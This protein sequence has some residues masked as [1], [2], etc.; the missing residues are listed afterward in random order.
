[1]QAL[2]GAE[3][4]AGAHNNITLT[5]N[6]TLVDGAVYSIA[7]NCTDAAGNAATPVTVAG[8]T[9]DAT[10]PTI[11][12]VAPTTGSFV[13][14]TQVSYTLSEN[15]ASATVTWTR[16]GGSADGSS[17]HAQALVGTE[18][19]AGAH[20]N[21]TITNNPTLASGAIYS[22]QF[23]C[24]DAAGHAATPVTMT[25]VTYDN[26][27]P[28]ISAVAPASN[29]FVNTTAVSYTLSENCTSASITWTRTGG[30]ADGSSPHVRALVGGELNAGTHS[31]VIITN[32][33]TLVDGA[34]YSIA[35]ACSDAAGNAAAPVTRTNITFDPSAVVIS[36]VAPASSSYRNNTQVS[37]TFSEA[38]ASASITWTRT[39]GNSDPS[40]PHVRALVG[41]ELAA[42]AHN[43]ITL[44]NNP[45]LV[46]GA[47]YSVQFDCTDFASNASTPITVT[48][49]TYDF[50]A[51]V[52][53]STA[54]PSNAF[55][56][57]TQVDYT[58]SEDCASASITWTHT[59]GVADGASPHVKA[60][61]GAELN[62]GAHTHITITNNPTLVDG[63]VYSIAFNCADAAG[64][65]A[66]T[67]T[68][69]SVTYDITQ[70]TVSISN[71]KDKSTVN[72]GY[73][74]GIANDN[75]GVTQ[76]QFNLD[77]TTW[78]NATYTAPDWKFALPTGASTWRDRTP[79]TIQVRAVDAAGNETFTPM[80]N[81]RK[82]NNRDVNGDG[83]ED[84]AIGA[85]AYSSSTGRAYVFYGGPS[86][87]TISDAASTPSILT[88]AANSNYFGR[89][90][91]MA[92]FNG[93][94]FGDLAVSAYGNNL[95][96]GLVQIYH[97]ASGGIP[98]SATIS[99]TGESTPA[100][101]SRFGSLMA[102]GDTNA[103]GYADLVASAVGY[104]S[105]RGRAYVFHGGSGGIA[106][107]AAGSANRI[108][109]GEAVTN[110]NLGGGLA[111][112]DFN[113]D[114]NT[115]LAI[116]A[117]T[118]TGANQGRV[119]ILS[120]SGSG[121][122]SVTTTPAMAI[123]TGENNTDY[124]GGGLA[125][126][127]INGDG[128][129]DLVVG[130]YGY[131]SNTGRA[132]IYHGSASGIPA[133][134]T[135]SVGSPA[136]VLTGTNTGAFF[137][138]NSTVADFNNDGFADVLVGSYGC[139]ANT[140]GCAYLFNGSATGISS[141]LASS[142]TITYT[143]QTASENF[144]R[145]VGFADVNGDGYLDAV[146]GA[147][148]YSSNSGRAFIFPGSSAGPS[149]TPSSNI[150]GEASSEFGIHVN[151]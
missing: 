50:T 4:T 27:V 33:P 84:V 88:G 115:D 124:F 98:G 110:F 109:D 141:G 97:G 23:D 90:M 69:T 118:G 79:H 122:P 136:T 85:W 100:A 78:N 99:I 28:V 68:N 120:G 107:T 12:G 13:N 9:F 75:V 19:N 41:A 131:S 67:V 43:N 35:F 6:P 108:I 144:G 48:N 40:S 143:G 80:I 139:T 135:S 8:V 82:G 128:I 22:V 137:T 14:H 15:C 92:D 127:D 111:L 113:G 133:N 119:Y 24:T 138:T 83:Y 16:T 7:F 96:Q 36:G 18:L 1:V 32:N 105:A 26:V 132:Y 81:V 20:N 61:L 130:A 11:T 93:D 47:V 45:V 5:N 106:A 94:G 59:G 72:T 30:S 21:I 39:G 17:P 151:R 38:C 87:I 10:P 103:D 77:T 76:V 126:G 65:L 66:S 148:F 147:N 145:A 123:G 55:V 37:Y 25:G 2:V 46:D 3:L 49:V 89:A 64:N 42:G 134:Q 149:T 29:A 58:L 34:I 53:S 104:S 73:V 60:L 129:T 146:V 91:T 121:L 117:P 86:G 95:N 71:L 54:P 102:A 112:G 101:T 142:A 63:A 140:A 57:H 74:I 31:N 125:A 70:P 52:I 150:S 56:N 44:T 62:A 114:G 51:P 116:A